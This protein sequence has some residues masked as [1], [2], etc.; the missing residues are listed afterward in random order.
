MVRFTISCH[1]LRQLR[2]HRG[3]Q[4]ENH[5]RHKTP[6]FRVIVFW[7]NLLKCK[8]REWESV[9]VLLPYGL[10]LHVEA[11]KSTQMEQLE[12]HMRHETPQVSVIVFWVNLLKCKA[13]EWETLQ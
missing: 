3:D 6:Q 8:A 5:R 10:W 12:N 9:V 2:T 13:R 7:D 11:T 4:L 1:M